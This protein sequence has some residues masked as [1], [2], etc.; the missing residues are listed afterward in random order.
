V[1]GSR[2]GL[3]ALRVRC[4]V[5]L[6]SFVSFVALVSFA[7]LTAQDY[8]ATLPLDHP[9]IEYSR[10]STDNAAARLA[11]KLQRGELQLASIPGS[12]A[13]ALPTL[14]KQLD[15]NPDSQLLVF[16]KTSV[17]SARIS[18]EHPRAIYFNDDVAVGFV[19]ESPTLEV[20]AVDPVWGPMFYA[21][22]IDGTG[23]AAIGRSESC[24]HCHHGPNT[25]GVP[26]VYVGSVIPRPTGAPSRD[27]QSAII[28]DH[29]TPFAERWGGWYVTARRGEP[30]GRANAV[31]LNP[32]DPETLVRDARQNLTSLAGFFDR[33]PYLAPTSDIVALMTFEHQTQVTNLLTR[34]AWE[35]R[36]EAANRGVKAPA[37]HGRPVPRDTG[38][39][40]PST[41]DAD[42]EDLVRSLLFSGEPRLHEPIEGVSPFAKTFAQRGPRDRRGRSLRDFDLRTRLFRYPL[43]YMIYSAQF[44]ALPEPVRQRV[45]K[46]VFEVLRGADRT[47]VLEILRDTKKD[48]PE[49]LRNRS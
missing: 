19:P 40:A 35:A 13:G 42:V 3:A 2:R 39:L 31:A 34:V 18:P 37:D 38:P 24:L 46:R 25:A 6:Y 17:Q 33:A 16:S 48:L 22:S 32:A 47:A 30:R 4:L 45:Y 43:S 11:E 41:L 7:R 14:L 28:T 29:R 20:S 36:M 10:R 26:G 8:K 12:A 9:A 15:V 44:G 49:Y 1:R 27:D 23:N 21:V 5:C